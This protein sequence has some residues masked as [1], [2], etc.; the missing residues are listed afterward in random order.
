MEKQG[1]SKGMEL[2]IQMASDEITFDATVINPK[3]AH[4][5]KSQAP[6]QVYYTLSARNY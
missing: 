2:E 6:S 1:R 5:S 3:L 4:S